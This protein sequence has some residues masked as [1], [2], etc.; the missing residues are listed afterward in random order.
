MDDEVPTTT[1]ELALAW[2]TRVAREVLLAPWTIQRVR[3]SLGVLPDELEALRTTLNDTTP[4][5]EETLG[6]LDGR[7]RGAVAG[8]SDYLSEAG[9]NVDYMYG[10]VEKR[11]GKAL[12]VF[13]FD[14]PDRAIQILLDGG[15]KVVTEA[16]VRKL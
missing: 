6:P 2:P 16:D 1:L 8:L 5:L 13:R 9:L 4:V 10:F 7:Y 14:K 15:V 12:M 3:R 11:T